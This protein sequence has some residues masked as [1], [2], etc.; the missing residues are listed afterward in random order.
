MKYSIHPKRI[1]IRKL[2]ILISTA[3]FYFQ[4][5]ISKYFNSKIFFFRIKKTNY[6]NQGCLILFNCMIFSIYV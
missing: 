1:L 4:N 2:D 6:K 5:L 3:S